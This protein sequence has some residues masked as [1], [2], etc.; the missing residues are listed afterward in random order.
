MKLFLAHLKN[1]YQQA[2][3][4]C[5]YAQ[6]KFMGRIFGPEKKGSLTQ[7]SISVVLYLITWPIIL[8]TQP[9]NVLFSSKDALL[10]IPVVDQSDR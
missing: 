1:N 4:D 5:G 6:G 3:Y 9:I 7:V 2:W 8:L 10:K